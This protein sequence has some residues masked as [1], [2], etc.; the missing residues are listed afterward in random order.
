[1]YHYEH[2]NVALD[3]CEV[4]AHHVEFRYRKK[5]KKRTHAV[6]WHSYTLL[7]GWVIPP[8]PRIKHTT[9]VPELST[10]LIS[11]TSAISSAEDKHNSLLKGWV[12]PPWP[13]LEPSTFETV[14]NKIEVPESK[15]S[16]IVLQR[17]MK[18]RGPP[19][20]RSTYGNTRRQAIAFQG[21]LRRKFDRSRLSVTKSMASR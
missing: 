17:G 10:S 6:R 7:E 5:G 2:M 14:Q 18:K 8:W 3:L 11:S 16:F 20:T 12:N 15:H 1:M 19:S 21:H 4:Y 9:L 13:Q